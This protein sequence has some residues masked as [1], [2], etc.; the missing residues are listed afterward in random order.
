MSIVQRTPS[1]DL[2]IQRG[3][4]DPLYFRF[5][6]GGVNGTL[7]SF[8][9]SLKFTFVNCGNTTTLGVGSGITLST[10]ETIAN[11]RA[12]VQLTVAQ[13]R[14]IP[15]GPMTYY[16]VQRTISGREEVI[17]SGNLIGEGGNNPDA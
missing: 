9:N 15:E 13:S 11:A 2:Y 3:A 16:E 14:T 4:P 10:D 5:R 12:T 17:F 1:K 8:D 6:A 7:V